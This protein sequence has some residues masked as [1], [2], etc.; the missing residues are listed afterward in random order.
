MTGIIEDSESGRLP[1]L[2]QEHLDRIRQHFRNAMGIQWLELFQGRNAI[3]KAKRVRGASSPS[4]VVTP[5]PK[6]P[7]FFPLS[8]PSS[9]TFKAPI[10]GSMGPLPSPAQDSRTPAAPTIIPPYPPAFSDGPEANET[11]A[12]VDTPEP[13]SPNPSVQNQTRAY[14]PQADGP[15]ADLEEHVAGDF[16]AGSYPFGDELSDNGFDFELNT[17]WQ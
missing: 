5:V 6:K 1:V 10:P 11:E 7:K 17:A 16:M 3:Q 15:P 4:F 9:A 2:N 14:S 8:H 13:P 12:P